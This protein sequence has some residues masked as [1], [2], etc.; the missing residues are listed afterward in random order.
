MGDRRG[1]AGPQRER[2][3][4]VARVARRPA[5]VGVGH[6][7]RLGATCWPR[8]VSCGRGSC[9]SS[10]RGSTVSGT[11]ANISRTHR[12]AVRIAAA[13]R[14]VRV[15][16]GVRGIEASIVHSTRRPRVRVELVVA[17]HRRGRVV[18][19]LDERTVVRRRVARGP[20]RNENRPSSSKVRSES[21]TMPT[22][23]FDHCARRR[24]VVDRDREVDAVA[25]CAAD[26]IRAAWIDG[27]ERVVGVGVVATPGPV[28]AIGRVDV[29]E[30][31][32]GPVSEKR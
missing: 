30:R 31:E 7:I 10:A 17:R 16:I 4:A 29:G 22:T 28:V 9:S 20:T 5:V 1:L 24:L 23:R 3:E 11:M 2:A 6:L 32:G 8:P 21:L 26:S 14:L 19:E 25:A 13:L 15:P 27:R 18:A 12:N